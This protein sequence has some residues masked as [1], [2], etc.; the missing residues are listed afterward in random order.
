[1]GGGELALVREAEGLGVS[2]PLCCVPTSLC[3]FRSS[4]PSL[5][6]SFPI[7]GRAVD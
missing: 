7:M 6:L 5:G 3:D 4:L 2:P 1:M